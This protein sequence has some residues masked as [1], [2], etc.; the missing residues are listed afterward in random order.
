M[1]LLVSNI[2][3]NLEDPPA[4]IEDETSAE[5]VTLEFR[6]KYHLQDFIAVIRKQGVRYGIELEQLKKGLLG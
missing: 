4:Y 6:D 2:I 1:S 5:K 3:D